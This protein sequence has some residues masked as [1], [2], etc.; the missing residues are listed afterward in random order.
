MTFSSLFSR[1]A[2]A[3][4]LAML[5]APS[6][7]AAAASGK[8]P[9]KVL[10]L[11]AQGFNAGEFFGPTATLR[12]LGY[13]IDIA[14]PLKGLVPLDKEMAKPN[15]EKDVP[16]DLPLEKAHAADYLALFVP[17]GY[18]PGFL[19]TNPETGRIVREFF[20][21]GKPVGM[22]CHGPR[23]LLRYGLAKDRTFTCLFTLPDELADLWVTRPFARY[24][25]Q[26][27]VRDRNLLTARYPNDVPAFAWHFAQLLAPASGIQAPATGSRVL[28]LA[29]DNAQPALTPHPLY[30]IR[31]VCE[32]AG[33]SV[34][35]PRI[36]DPQALTQALEIPPDAVVLALS[37][38]QFQSIPE[39]VRVQLAGAARTFCHPALATMLPDAR[40]FD[41]S[42]PLQLAAALWSTSTPTPSHPTREPGAASPPAVVSP[43]PAP[44]GGAPRILFAARE[45]FDDASYAELLGPPAT[46]SQGVVVVAEKRGS[47]RGVNGLQIQA[48]QSYDQPPPALQPG[49]VIVAPGFFWPQKNENARQSQQ[50][51]WIEERDALDR[52]R[53]DWLLA[54]RAKGATILAVGLDALRLG[55]RSEFAGKKFATTEQAVWSFPK[56]AGVYT[57]EPVMQTDDRLLTVRRAADLPAALDL[58]AP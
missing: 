12:A 3:A 57:R 36:G 23:L 39:T 43:E 55:K 7:G 11:L 34:T 54:C 47:V 44:A 56:G 16:V 4:L 35:T 13:Q 19:E 8:A 31:A 21:A 32:A 9:P 30:L 51:V 22:I 37:P 52:V 38:E 49:T 5:I 53:E 29:S 48:T 50:P 17:G 14:S 41:P 42:K 40:P 27:V 2:S 58:I 25:D 15:P 46:R 28:L 18:S 20:D 10:V 33:M 1:I 6:A 45:G 24:L 26:P